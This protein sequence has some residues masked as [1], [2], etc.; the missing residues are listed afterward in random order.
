M[1]IQL[2]VCKSTVVKY[3]RHGRV[4]ETEGKS[5]ELLRREMSGDRNEVLNRGERT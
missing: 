5:E 1:E 2:T 3:K 4:T